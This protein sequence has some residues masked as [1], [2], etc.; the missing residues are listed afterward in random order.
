MQGIYFCILLTQ[1]I[2][3]RINERTNNDT[4]RPKKA[5]SQVEQKLSGK[6]EDQFFFSLFD[7]QKFK[8]EINFLFNKNIHTKDR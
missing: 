3:S 7:Q 4:T 2:K 8:H 5:S 6:S 1:E